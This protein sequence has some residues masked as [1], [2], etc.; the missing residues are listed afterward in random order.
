MDLKVRG[1]CVRCL[2]GRHLEVTPTLIH[3]HPS[4]L[5][6]IN[7]RKNEPDIVNTY[8]HCSPITRAYDIN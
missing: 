7:T 1:F 6:Y 4:M 8:H 5:W 3:G 2:H